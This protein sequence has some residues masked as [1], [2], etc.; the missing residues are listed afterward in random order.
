MAADKKERREL[1]KALKQ[2]RARHVELLKKVEKARARFE[3]RTRKLQALEAKIAELTRLTYQPQAG[4]LGQ[5]SAGDNNLRPARLIFNPKSGGM[6]GTSA[7]ELERIIGSLRAHGI[8]AEI[9]WKTSGK[10]VREL[11]K[12]VV[13]QGEDFI[14]VAAGDGTIEDVASQ[15]VGTKTTLGI[16][17]VGTMNNIARA[18][19]IP[20]ELDDACQLLAMNV[21]RKIDVG[22]VIANEKPQ[23]EYFLET[24]GVGLTAIAIPAGQAAEKGKWAALPRALRKLFD[25]QPCPIEVELDNGEVIRANSQMVTV[26]NGPLMGQNILIAPDA[27][28]DDGLLDIAV[29]DG[30]TKGELLSYFMSSSNGARTYHPKIRFYRARHV[31]IRSNQPIDAHSDKDVIEGKQTLEIE[32]IPQALTVLVGQGFALTLPVEVA[33]SVPPL[34]GPQPTTTQSGNGSNAAN[35]DKK[36]E[37]AE[38]ATP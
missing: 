38:S 18:L 24:A 6:E 31:I 22:R 15:L 10:A 13:D 28:M 33:A 25:T 21:A 2:A 19:G 11:V 20:L 12:E 9:G 36:T 29:Y 32:V 1:A 27:K 7:K 35:G 34:S 37:V 3:K 17:P 5:A 23:V 4:R 8:R 14:I 30:M 16:I 26:S